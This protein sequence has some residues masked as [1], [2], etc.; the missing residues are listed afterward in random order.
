LAQFELRRGKAG[1]IRSSSLGKADTSQGG[2]LLAVEHFN[3]IEFRN[4]NNEI[5]HRYGLPPTI[6]LSHYFRYF[7]FD[8]WD[9]H[10]QQIK[11]RFLLTTLFLLRKIA[12][13]RPVASVLE[14]GGTI[15]EN[16]ALL[17]QLLDAEPYD[18]TLRFAALDN[19][20][21]GVATGEQIFF[22]DPNCH[23]MHGDASTLD[24]LAD[25]SVDI[26]ISNGVH[27]IL[28]DPLRSI[29]DALRVARVAVNLHLLVSEEEPVTY[30]GAG[31]EYTYQ[32]PNLEQVRDAVRGLTPVYMYRLNRIWINR[33]KLG[34]DDHSDGK[35]LDE[36][37]IPK[38]HWETI[39]LSHA[40]ILPE[41]EMFMEILTR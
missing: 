17:R 4:T 38:V 1:D 2:E 29:S 12:L 40:P 22:D 25:N 3:R 30:R 37:N 19:D 15:G 39:I 16:Y 6:G 7:L 36:E 11:Y 31:N 20:A 21:N 14:I 10:P 28:K 32:A 26:V 9:I 13:H 33:I 34:D 27:N 23:F 24:N 5:V 18:L 35:Y 8:F 41:V